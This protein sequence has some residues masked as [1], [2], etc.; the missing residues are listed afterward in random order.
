MSE[1]PT[2]PQAGARRYPRTFGGL[3]A[4]MIVLVLAVLGYWVVQKALNPTP[5]IGPEPVDY[6]DTAAAAQ[7]AGIPIVYPTSLP[8]GWI[9]TEVRLTP[10][11]RLVWG[12]PMLTDEERFVGLQQEDE[13]LHTL[14]DT[15]V[16]ENARQGADV[17]IDSPVAS[18]WS[19]WTDEGGDHAFAAE[20]GETVVLVYGSAPATDLKELVSRLSTAPVG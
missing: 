20:V 7:E 17:M 6:L 4:S 1:P 12:I 3:V 10:G 11:D 13:D 14:L 15:Y 16:D 5:E 8:E 18:R 2:E 19:S 9:A